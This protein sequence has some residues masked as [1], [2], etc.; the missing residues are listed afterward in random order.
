MK[1]ILLVIAGLSGGGAEKQAYETFK[2]LNNNNY[3]CYL[4]IFNSVDK[5]NYKF[6]DIIN[7][8][9]FISLGFN[10]QTRFKSYKITKSLIRLIHE[11]DVNTVFSFLHL[12]N[13]ATR[14]AK[15]FSMNSFRLISSIRNDFQRQYSL[16]NKIG[17]YMLLY[18]SD[19]VS[20]N[21]LAS[22]KH[23][24]NIKKTF[25]LPNIIDYKHNEYKAQSYGSKKKI[26]ILGRLSHQKN[27]L[28]V[29]DVA[30]K[31]RG[32]G[33]SFCFYGD[34]YLKEE[35]INIVNRMGLDNVYFYSYSDEIYEKFDDF[36]MLFLPS[37]Y[38][39]IS[40]SMIESML[41]GLPVLV[42]QYANNSEVVIDNQNGFVFEGFDCAKVADKIRKISSMKHEEVMSLGSLA[43]RRVLEFFSTEKVLKTLRE[44]L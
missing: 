13:L 24:Q 10:S 37:F 4:V 40:N 5:I 29:L 30:K 26:L 36:S 8:P 44:Y 1:N 25:F 3:N 2:L 16:K 18:L 6:R 39:G 21:S 17:E 19:F 28:F 23:F 7:H 31:L 20:S 11:K 42:S 12:A 9:N 35:L 32:E 33:F 27:P 22:V 34:G 41:Y 15:L 43:N 38:E 14:L